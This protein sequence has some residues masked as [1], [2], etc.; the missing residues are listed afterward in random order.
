MVK[1]KRTKLLTIVDKTLHRNQKMI[2][3]NNLS[4]KRCSVISCMHDYL[5]FRMTSGRK[6]MIPKGYN[7]KPQIEEGQTMQWSKSKQIQKD[8]Q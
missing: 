3:Q 2:G 4:Q 5:S 1:T 7:Y 6:L 8:K